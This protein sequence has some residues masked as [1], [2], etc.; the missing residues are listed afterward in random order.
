MRIAYNPKSASGPLTTA[1]TGDYLNAIT[2]DLIGHNIFARGE[3]FKGTDTTYEVFRKATQDA[4]GYNGLVPAPS[5]T[6]NSIRFLREDGTW[7]VPNQRPIK[8]GGG[9]FIT[10]L[11]YNK[12]LDIYP[13]NGITIDYDNTGKITINS[14]LNVDG[15][16]SGTISDAFTQAKVGAVTLKATT[17]KSLTFSNGT[18]IV[19]TPNTITNTIQ[20]A[21]PVMTGST[22]E[23][24]GLEGLVP[25]PVITDRQLFLR[26]DGTWAAPDIRDYGLVTNTYDGVVPKF[27]SSDGTINNPD[28]WILT[29]NNNTIGW[30]KL[31]ESA[32]TTGWEDIT[33]KPETYAPSQHEHPTIQI[34][35]LTGYSYNYILENEP[36]NLATTDTLNQAL[37]KLEHKANQGVA[38]FN[39]YMSVTAEDTDEYINKWQEIVDF[40]DDLKESDGN[41]LDQFV[42]IGTNQIIIGSK[43]FQSATSITANL[44]TRDII[45]ETNDTYNLGTSSNVW[46]EVNAAIING[47][48]NGN[49]IG[50]DTNQLVFQSAANVTDFIPAPT[51]AELYLTYDGTSFKWE[52][53]IEVD[54]SGNASEANSAKKIKLKAEATDQVYPLVY[55]DP[56]NIGKFKSAELFVDTAGESGYNP[57]SDLFVADGFVKH[58]SDNEHILLGDGSHRAISDFLLKEE[59]PAQELSNNLMVINKQLAVTENWLDTG[60]AGIDLETG[61]YIVQVYVNEGNMTDCY[62]SGTMSWYNN[63][64][65]GD[66]TD[67][68]LLHRSGKVYSDTIYLRTVMQSNESLKLQ[69]AAD[70]G[71]SAYNYTFKFKRMI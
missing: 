26:G 31:P 36:I 1:P 19:L 58:G 47:N 18:G 57:Y 29:I 45:P 13:G 37:A 54:S 48:L 33:D 59:S 23:Q 52:P 34:T 44:T 21:A 11:D 10:E 60:I 38:A 53:I 24:D 5:Y 65:T 71:L 63:S 55:T 16:F 61:T 25:K 28:N 62:W 20:I 50:G 66:A 30:Y 8:L 46:K 67:E 2:F 69:I 3:M 9:D 12:A 27:D 14:T 56:K 70:K 7:I 42:T 15:D 51:S 49:I 32:F 43:T 40:I 41:I 6:N 64:C 4:V 17:N 35:S 39:W 22:A 68:I